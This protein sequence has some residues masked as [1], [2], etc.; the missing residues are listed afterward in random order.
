MYTATFTDIAVTA[1]QDLLS[2]LPATQ[3]P[4]EVCRVRLSQVGTADMVAGQEESLA[5][6]LRRGHTTAPSG[7]ATVTPAPRD[8][9]QAT[10]GVTA[11]RNDTTIASAGTA[12]TVC[13]LSFHVMAGLDEVIPPEYRPRVQNA[14]WVNVRLRAAPAD[15]L[16]MSGTVW[17]RTV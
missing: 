5:V 13:D 6:E 2:V 14:N 4:I 17:F 3:R 12:V 11:R 15:S 8:S 9:N 1:A 10:S 7:G 16:T